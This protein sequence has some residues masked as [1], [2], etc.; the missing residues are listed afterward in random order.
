[1]AKRRTGSSRAKRP[2]KRAK[3]RL[4]KRATGYS[5]QIES[6]LAALA[7]DIR[8]PLT[9]ILALAEL[10]AASD[11]GE[12]ERRWATGVKTAA[13]HLAQLTTIVCDAVRVDVAG[14]TLQQD[15]FSPRRVV[16]DVGL[17]LSARART[18]GLTAKITIADNV[19]DTVT[20]DVVRL[21]AALENL[22]DNAVK[23]TARGGVKLEAS[24]SPAARHRVRLVFVVTDSGIGLKPE[25]IKRLFKPFAQASEAVAR[26]YGGTGLGLMLVRRLARA[27]GG[28]L[29]VTSK[30]GTGSVFRLEVV[31][32]NGVDSNKRP[33]RGPAARTAGARERLNILYVE[34]N[35]YGRVVLNA[36]LSG[37]GHRADF[38]SSGEAAIEQVRRVN[39]DVLLM[40][41]VLPGIDGFETTRRI[42]AL[43][44]PAGRVPIIGLSGRDEAASEQAARKAGMDGYMA[45]PVSPR[46]LASALAKLRRHD[47]K[48]G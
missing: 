8:T 26:L 46:D 2:R 18:S 11:L 16:E 28:D 25:E 45:K 23:F 40:D 27:M 12:R 5:R 38:V 31:V 43:A 13:E 21:R 19:P 9:G 36:L 24:A 14:L 6:A 42:R 20:G 3:P 30:A 1:M 32:D 47:G 10:L 35:P 34:D 7:H 44:A 15:V 39:Y 4:R 33:Q 22:I 29:T 17:S 41:V 48:S 37:L